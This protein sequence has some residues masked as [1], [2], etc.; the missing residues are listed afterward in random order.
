MGEKNIILA[1]KKYLLSSENLNMKNMTN[2]FLNSHLCTHVQIN[3]FY[4]D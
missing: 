2:F 3:S 4:S 1:L